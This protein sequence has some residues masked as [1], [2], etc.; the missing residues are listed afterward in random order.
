MKERRSKKRENTWRIHQRRGE[1][2]EGARRRRPEH[3]GDP[4]KDKDE[5]E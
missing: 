3:E 1:P 4:S 5:R 2:R